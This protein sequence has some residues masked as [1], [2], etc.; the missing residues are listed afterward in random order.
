MWQSPAV[1]HTGH[2]YSFSAIMSDSG[3]HSTPVST[4]EREGSM[5]DIMNFL[6]TMS[7]D[8]NKR[9]DDNHI[10]REMKQQNANL[11]GDINE[12]KEQDIKF[13]EMNAS[14][15]KQFDKRLSG[16]DAVS[17]THLDVYKRQ[18][19]YLIH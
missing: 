8:N 10:L 15:V 2:T 5:A 16:I 7:H 14:L 9:F 13:N 1:H 6:R 3:V 11:R 19:N 18:V 12:I 17:Y 4:K